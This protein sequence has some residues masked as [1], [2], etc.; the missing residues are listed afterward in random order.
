MD[1]CE[2]ALRLMPQDTFHANIDS[3]NGLVSPGM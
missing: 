1:T 2:I 3:G